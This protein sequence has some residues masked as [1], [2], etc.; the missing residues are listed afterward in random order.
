MRSRRL[1]AVAAA[2]VVAAGLVAACSDSPPPAIDYVVDA[3][4]DTY[5]ANTVDGNA[6]GVLMA[7]TRMLPGFSFLGAAGQVT[8]DRD[9]GT[10]TRQPGSRLT[11]RYE[12]NPK[13]VF[14]DGQPLDC[15]DM[16]LA[17]AAM[18]GRFQG[19]TPATTEGYR[20]IDSVECRPGERAA[21]VTFAAGRDIRNWAALFGAGAMLPAHV[22][23]R[24][25][26]IANVVD[27]IRAGN[28]AV[29]DRIA[30]FWNT[31]FAVQPGGIDEA[32]LP[33]SGPYRIDGHTGD[34]G[35]VLVRNDKWW[36]D[37]PNADRI[38]VWGRGTD[39]PARLA[40]GR[41]DVADVTAGLGDEPIGGRAPEQERAPGRALG[42]EGLV[43]SERGVFADA[44]ARRAFASCVP[45]D[46]LARRFGEGAQLWNLRTVA[47]ADNLAGQINGEFGREYARPNTTRAREL[48]GGGEED[49]PPMRVRLVYQAPAERWRQMV[50]AIADSCRPAGITVEDASAPDLRPGALGTQVDAMLVANGAGFSAAGSA[51]PIRSAYQL[52]TGD[53]LNLGNYRN[54]Q[55]SR[56]IDDLGVASLGTDRLG[57]IRTIE[58]AAW[59]DVPSIPLFAAPRDRRWGERIDAVVPGLGRSG[60]G[61]NMDRWTKSE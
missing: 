47:P 12:F 53:P 6:R 3:T 44:S 18:S 34:G 17:W 31:G 13:A 27:P 14:S 57:L 46:D 50:A 23:A 2:A 7:T 22:V 39:M 52:R 20:D 60:T 58:N 5:N 37:P 33:S 54:P 48:R 43:L 61:W 55:V 40:E 1:T 30:D 10:V 59:A 9:V 26:G 28:R 51:D 24:A 16:V 11:L 21:T 4:V 32:E 15:D 8:P 19:F 35:L 25:A 45:R 41:Y 38:V 36:G 56:A 42:V 29:I 49:A